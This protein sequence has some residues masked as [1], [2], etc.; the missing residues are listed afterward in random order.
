MTPPTHRTLERKVAQARFALRWEI[1]WS[2]LH[3]PALVLM[4]F[5]AAVF[6]GLLPGLNEISRYGLL[7]LFALAFLWSLKSLFQPIWPTRQAAIRR[8]EQVSNLAHRPVS[9]LGDRL[10]DETMAPQSQALWEEHRLRQLRSLDRMRAGAPRS[11]WRDL[12]PWALRVPAG[13]ALI[14]SLLLGPGDPGSSLA[15]S[16]RLAPQVEA[17]PLSLDAWLKPPAYTGKPP[18]LLTSPAMAERLKVDPEIVTPENTSLTIRLTGAAKPRLA[19]HEPDNAGEAGKEIPDLAATSKFDAGLFQAEAKL[20]RPVVVRLTDGGRTVAS[21]PIVMVPDAPPAVEITADPQGDSSGALVVKWKTAD[22]YGVSGLSSEISLS[23]TQEDGE[24]IAGNGVFLFDPPQ[25]PIALRRAV[26]REEAGT[27]SADLTAHPWAGL[28]VDMVLKAR[29]AAGHETTSAVKSFKLPERLFIKPLAKALIEQR[30]RLIM[31]PAETGDVEAMLA[32]LLIY[33]EGLMQ[34][35][36]THVAIAAALSQIRNARGH[37]DISAAIDFLWQIAIG[38]EEGDLADA[39][40]ALESLRQELAKALAEGASPERIAE[41]MDK[42][43]EAMDRYMKSMMAEAQKR[44]QQQG[45]Q[46]GQQPQPGQMVTPQDL[47]KMLDTIEKL[48]ESGARDA[49]QQL[50]SELE[51]ILRNLQPGMD[52]QQSGPPRD[53]PMSK[54]LDQ[55]SQMMRRQQQL[56]DDTQRMREPG[57]GEPED[58]EEQKPGAQGQQ[59][60]PNGLAGEQQQLSRM[61]EQFMRQLGQNGVQPSPSLG[62]AGKEMQGAEG[63]LRQQNREGALGQQGQALAKLREGAQSMVREMLQQGQGQKDNQ[64]RNGEARGDDRDPLGRPMPNRSEDFGPER[65]MLPS[66]LAIRRAREILDTLR[67][68]AGEQGRPRLERDY[69]DRLLRGLY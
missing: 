58:G 42:L 11:A 36:G 40:A 5:G 35:S 28:T 8:I 37:D 17:T 20:T 64:G 3:V 23:D 19:F 18:V 56:M 44:M 4:L 34:G 66:E 12:D 31:E 62:E 59:P 15:D 39:R 55:L 16:L 21:W 65:D 53:S 51:N 63:S 10:A 45:Q 49:A 26:P 47:Q 43:R 27:T 52:P 38:I 68:R 41:L 1:F 54:M 50:L 60:D 25:F 32:A 7:G 2:A 13:L 14:L 46:P 69:I 9:A 29:D 33:P 48:A 61:L 30:R 67:A 24:G 22:D 6:S 57:E